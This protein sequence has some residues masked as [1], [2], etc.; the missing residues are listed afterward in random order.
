VIR[1]SGSFIQESEGR[2]EMH[3]HEDQK[4]QRR[5]FF[6]CSQDLLC[7]RAI[8]SS[9]EKEE[10]RRLVGLLFSCSPVMAPKVPLQGEQKT[11]S[12]N[13]GSLALMNSCEIYK[14]L[15]TGPVD[16]TARSEG[17]VNTIALLLSWP[18]VNPTR[19]SRIGRPEGLRYGRNDVTCRLAA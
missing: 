8:A 7:M 11:R 9:Q 17:Q 18:P 6:S 12:K 1:F 10:N 3:L 19:D 16:F 14:R 5:L 4:N 2:R 13:N 15:L